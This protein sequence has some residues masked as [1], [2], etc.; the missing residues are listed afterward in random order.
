MGNGTSVETV[1]EA[2]D[3]LALDY[4]ERTIDDMWMRRVLWRRYSSRFEP[5]DRILD[6]A[7]G[8]GLDSLHLAALG[9]RVT[10]VDVSPG[11]IASLRHK[12][13]AAPHLA[14]HVE[15]RVAEAPELAEWPG[16]SYAG[17]VSSFAGLNTVPD[18]GSFAEGTAH[19]LRARGRMVLHL[20]SPAGIGKRL[21]LFS[22][23]RWRD[24]GAVGRRRIRNISISGRVVPHRVLP[25]LETYRR[26]FARRFRLQR[27]YAM[28]FL[29]PQGFGRRL[30]HGALAAVGGLELAVGR[31][32]PFLDWGRFFV[33]ELRKNE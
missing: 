7:C 30:P 18:L 3:A 26:F 6:F 8:T 28:G 23:F 24:A 17:V 9:M 31:Y 12:I 5:G 10:A 33:M 27:I 29:W 16:G 21:R 22:A 1:A 15:T 25:P 13:A 14:E 2:Y 32:R 11:M 19:L 4:D 20:L